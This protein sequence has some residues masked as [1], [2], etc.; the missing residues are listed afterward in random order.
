MGWV[1]SVT[2]GALGGTLIPD[3]IVGLDFAVT[4]FFLV[5]A[6]DAFVV[7]PSAPLP[8]IAVTC[9]LVGRALFGTQMLVPALVLFTGLLLAHCALRS[10]KDRARA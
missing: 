10:R 9:A 8:L 6:I 3:S 2:A 1:G 4:A 5:L 7:T